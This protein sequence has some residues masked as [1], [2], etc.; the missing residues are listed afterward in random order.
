MVLFAE[1]R[2][3]K[4]VVDAFKQ[5]PRRRVGI[6]GKLKSEIKIDMRSSSHASV[7]SRRFSLPS[8]ARRGSAGRPCG[9]SRWTLGEYPTRSKTNGRGLQAVASDST[10]FLNQPSPL[11]GTEHSRARLNLSSA[12]V[13]SSQRIDHAL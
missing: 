3:V 6:F 13:T 5:Q 4:K 9:I 12:S 7:A 2:N 8:L 1:S 11:H 10:E